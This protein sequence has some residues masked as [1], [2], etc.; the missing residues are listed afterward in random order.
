MNWWQALLFG[1]SIGLVIVPIFV[2]IA[3]LKKRVTERMSIKRL[4]KEGKYLVPI[5]PRDWDTNSPWKNQINPNDYK[6]DLQSINTKIFHKEIDDNFIK[7]CFKHIK[8]SRQNGKTDDEI[9]EEMRI[10]EYPE[11]LVKHLFLMEE[12]YGRPTQ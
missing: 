12:N 1:G 5:D 7:Q 9:R 4:I 6:K 11:D 3:K 8:D 10:K 2:G